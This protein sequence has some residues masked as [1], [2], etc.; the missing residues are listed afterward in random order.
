MAKNKM[1]FGTFLVENQYLTQDQA[2]EVLEA[3]KFSKMPGDF[4]ERF[5]RIAVNKGYISEER[6][7]R[8]FLDKS[9]H[10]QEILEE[11]QEK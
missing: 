7:R 9:R 11:E 1:K 8:A 4:K 6:L 3:Q 10:D 2:E 5:G